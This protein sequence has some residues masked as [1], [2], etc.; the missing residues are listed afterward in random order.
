LTGHNKRLG[1][2]CLDSLL[3]IM[4]LLLRSSGNGLKMNTWQPRNY[5]DFMYQAL[6]AYQLG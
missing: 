3:W 2:I 1:W 4:L 6:V 5:S